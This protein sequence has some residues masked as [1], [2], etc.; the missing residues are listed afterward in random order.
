VWLWRSLLSL[1]LLLLLLLRLLLRT[2]LPA[3]LLLQPGLCLLLA[4]PAA[5]IPAAAACPC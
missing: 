3:A 5:D 2:Q 1:L 4:F